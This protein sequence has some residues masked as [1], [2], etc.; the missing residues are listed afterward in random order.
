MFVSVW[1]TSKLDGGVD[2][3]GLNNFR[4]KTKRSSQVPPIQWRAQVQVQVP[5]PLAFAFT[6]SDKIALWRITFI[7]T[8]PPSFKLF[9]S[10]H[11]RIPFTLHH[12][13]WKRFLN[14]NVAF[15][16]FIRLNEISLHAAQTLQAC[17]LL[18]CSFSLSSTYC[19]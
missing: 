13:V 10:L 12:C 7:H 9:L 19:H 15:A 16:R 14:N 11:L 8:T 6:L 17:L 5:R 3:Y 18:V 4:K 1:I 2:A